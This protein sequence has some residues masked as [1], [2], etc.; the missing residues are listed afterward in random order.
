MDM[1]LR[2]VTPQAS[3]EFGPMRDSLVCR[4]KEGGSGQLRA[5]HSQDGVS[6]AEKRG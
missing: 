6:Q 5:Q 4:H 3:T 1:D 2:T